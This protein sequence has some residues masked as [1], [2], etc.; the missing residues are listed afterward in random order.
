MSGPYW[1]GP[2]P[3]VTKTS[4]A[5]GSRSAPLTVITGALTPGVVMKLWESAGVA[6]EAGNWGTCAVG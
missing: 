4:P 6:G 5:A 3:L 1:P 2:G